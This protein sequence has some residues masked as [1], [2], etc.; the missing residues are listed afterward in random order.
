[1]DRH[2]LYGYVPPSAYSVGNSLEFGRDKHPRIPSPHNRDQLGNWAILS[3]NFV[4][5]ASFLGGIKEDQ[6]REIW[7]EES[8]ASY[9]VGIAQRRSLG[10]H[11]LF[12]RDQ[13]M[14]KKMKV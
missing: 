4:P 1:V 12:R 5:A 7:V 2:A 10:F 9:H 11:I 13:E 6:F 8:L 3:R 14:V